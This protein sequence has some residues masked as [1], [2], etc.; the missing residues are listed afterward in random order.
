MVRTKK[1]RQVADVRL[2]QF[3]LSNPA[4]SLFGAFL[5]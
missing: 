1:S 5:G 4:P 2:H 3:E